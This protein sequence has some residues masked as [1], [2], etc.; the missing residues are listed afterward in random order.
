MNLNLIKKL[1]S[2]NVNKL[3]KELIKFLYSKK[4]TNIIYNEDYII[5]E[6]KIP[7]CLIA[8]LDTVFKKYPDI[9]DFYYDSNKKVLWS[10]YGAGFDDRAGVYAIMQLLNKNLY[11]HV[12]FT[13]KEEIGGIGALKLIEKYSNFPFDCKMLIELDRANENDMVFYDCKNIKFINQIKKFGFEEQI[14]LFTDISILSPAWNIAGVNLSIGYEDEHTYI[15]RL[16]CDWCDQTIEKVI[17]I[18]NNNQ[19]LSF[20]SYLSSNCCSSCGKILN[21]NNCNLIHI[22]TKIYSLCDKCLKNYYDF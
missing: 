16:H 15:E 8:H 22:S 21:Q 3:R 12:I 18:L 14:G 10:P 17:T 20:Y 19:M 1:C 2:F 5:A 6:G 9:D 4:Y 13:N 11:P 7:I